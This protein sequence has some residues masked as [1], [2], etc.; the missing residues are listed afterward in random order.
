M[1]SATQVLTF[2]IMATD[3]LTG[4][5]GQTPV[6]RFSKNGATAFASATQTVTEMQYGWYKLT[7]ATNNVDTMGELA[8]H[9]TATKGDDGDEKHYVGPI[10]A[11]AIWWA[12]A[13]VAAPNTS[14]VPKVDLISINGTT[15][16]TGAAMLGVNVY[17][18]ATATGLVTSNAPGIPN[19]NTIAIGGTTATTGAALLGVNV[20]SWAT[21]TGTVTSA[22]AGIPKTDLISIQGTTATT[23]AAMLGV[24]VYSWATATGTVTSAAAGIPKTDLISVQGTTATTGAAMIGV[25]VYSWA[26]ATGLVPTPNVAGRPLVDVTHVSGTLQTAGDIIGDTNDIQTRLP[27]ALVGGRMDSSIGNVQSAAITATG[28]AADAFSASGLATGAA[29]KIAD[30]VWD[31]LAAGHTA[32][33]SF[34]AIVQAL[35]SAGDP[36]ATSIPGSYTATQAGGIVGT[37]LDTTISSRSTATQGP[38]ATVIADAILDRD[39]SLGTDSGSSTVRTPRQALRFLRNK[40]SATATTGALQVFKEDDA[41]VSWSGVITSATDAEPVVGNDPA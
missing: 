15:A 4:A 37:N 23:G 8:V 30:Q 17:S 18:W 32:T 16:T 5:T 29:D 10:G 6:V 31:E 41:T 34:G 12:S 1:N 26:T 24:N 36:W 21:A 39:M 27:A 9:V 38:T 25:N 35:S 7:L 3:H 2:L 33:T 14:G 40:W 20:Y 28:F 11:N 19:V 13:T 22:A